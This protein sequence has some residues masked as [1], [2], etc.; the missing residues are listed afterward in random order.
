VTGSAASFAA[1]ASLTL[2]DGAVGGETGDV[3]RSTGLRAHLLHDVASG[4]L[5]IL[6]VSLR[7]LLDVV[8]KVVN[9]RHGDANGQNGD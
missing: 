2:D 5:A 6:Q 1:A 9:H 7:L 8:D 3:D 4:R